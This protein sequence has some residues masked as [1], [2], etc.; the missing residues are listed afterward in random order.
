MLTYAS[1]RISMIDYDLA[2]KNMID[3]QIHPSGVVNKAILDSFAA[4]PRELFVPDKLQSIAYMDQSLS[5]G[6]GRYLIE[7]SM[8]AKLL[9]VLAP[10][11]EDVVLDI[12]ASSGY[13]SAI[14]S[15]LVTTIIAIE[16]N[17]RQMDRATRM[18]SKLELCNI[19]LI[20]GELADGH[21]EDAPYSLIILNGSV[22]KVPQSLLDQLADEGRLACFIREHDSPFGKAVIY[23]KNKQGHVSFKSIFDAGIPYLEECMG[24]ASFDF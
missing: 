6:Q 10:S 19:A 16:K 1:V 2:R 23:Y 21:A 4:I 5:L 20:E 13:S 12:G 9:Q 14:L 11:K 18:W 8:Y 17:K 3:G 22:D 24:S 15:P 7:P